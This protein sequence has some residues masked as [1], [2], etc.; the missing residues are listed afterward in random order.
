M[1]ENYDP[2]SNPELYAFLYPIF[3]SDTQ[4]L[5]YLCIGKLHDDEEE[6]YLQSPSTMRYYFSAQHYNLVQW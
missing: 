5:N 6:Y 2:F 4:F 3:F 1:L